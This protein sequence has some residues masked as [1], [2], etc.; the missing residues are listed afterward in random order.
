MTEPG[1]EEY[2]SVLARRMRAQR[3]DARISVNWKQRLTRRSPFIPDADVRQL[4]ITRDRFRDAAPRCPARCGTFW[5][6]CWKRSVARSNASKGSA[7]SCYNEM[8][9]AG[10]LALTSPLRRISKRCCQTALETMRT[11]EVQRVSDRLNAI[12]LNMIGADAAQRAI[13]RRARI[14]PE[15]RILIYGLHD[16]R[17]DT[18]LDLI[19]RVWSQP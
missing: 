12:S 13:I 17:L 2:S 5:R 6:H 18:S 8:T 10:G 11:R 14:T 9:R 15:F 1:L 16:N 19:R 3:D 7:A 4:R